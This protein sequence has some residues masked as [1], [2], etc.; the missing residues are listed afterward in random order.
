MTEFKLGDIVK[1]KLTNNIRD[2]RGEFITGKKG[3]I[4]SI[5]QNGTYILNNNQWCIDFKKK[6]YYP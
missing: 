2:W 3:K 1:I 4:T 5:Q 6:I